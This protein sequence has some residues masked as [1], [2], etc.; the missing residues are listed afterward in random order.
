MAIIMIR[1]P[2]TSL[3]IDQEAMEAISDVNYEYLFWGAYTQSNLRPFVT[4]DYVSHHGYVVATAVK[5]GIQEIE[6]RID[7]PRS[8]DVT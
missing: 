5:M 1:V 2:P 3:R 4:G 8:T 7:D 6:V